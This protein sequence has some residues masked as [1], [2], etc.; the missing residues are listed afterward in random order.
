MCGQGSEVNAWGVN[1]AGRV[2]GIRWREIAETEP[3]GGGGGA[4]FLKLC[5]H[6]ERSFM[7][8]QV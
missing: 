5:N 7:S 4:F 1:L 6:Y 2:A 3:G 8:G